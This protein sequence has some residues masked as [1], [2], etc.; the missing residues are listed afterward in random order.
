M[1][2][3]NQIKQKKNYWEL[4]CKEN[5]TKIMQINFDLILHLI[6]KQWILNQ[7]R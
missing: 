5:Q 4:E 1:R 2:V 7:A 3:K 6:D